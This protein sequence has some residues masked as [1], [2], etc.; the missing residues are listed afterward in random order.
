MSNSLSMKPTPS[1]INRNFCQMCKGFR[2]LCGKGLCPILVKAKSIAEIQKTF[3][4]TDFFGASPPSF[5]VGEYGYPKVNIGPLVPP[6]ASQD[7]TIYDA[8]D[9]WIHRTMDEIV[10]Y[11][12]ALVRGKSKIKVTSARDPGK[13]LEITQ[14]L[15]MSEKPVDTEMSFIKRPKLEIVFSPRIPPAGPS[16]NIK[17]ARITEDPRV[18]RQ[19]DK[20]VSD[21]DLKA[22]GG[23]TTLYEEDIPQRQITRLLSA[24]LFGQK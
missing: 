19:V 22:V 5:F 15:V 11:R 6:L 8:E 7:T 16:G 12:T 3:S 18:P 1:E 14:E 2:K 23:I 10:G 24:G 20:I 21:T 13:M 9:M 4:K 17:K